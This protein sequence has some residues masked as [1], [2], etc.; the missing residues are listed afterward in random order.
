[1]L[2]STR[3]VDT[4]LKADF[5]SLSP[6]EQGRMLDLLKKVDPENYN[7]WLETFVRKM[8]DGSSAIL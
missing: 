6:S 2:A 1:M 4:T 3:E 5:E 7:W 8:P